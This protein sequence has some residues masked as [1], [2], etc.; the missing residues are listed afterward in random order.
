MKIYSIQNTSMPKPL[1]FKGSQIGGGGSSKPDSDFDVYG[2]DDE[3]SQERRNYIRE[4]Y[5]DY[6]I[7]YYTD[8]LSKEH[9][10]SDEKLKEMVNELG[11]RPHKVDYQTVIE[12]PLW[13][14]EQ[15]GN[16]SYRGQS[17][18]D[19]PE[20][21]KDLKEAGIERVID[22]VGYSGL[23]EKVEK[24]GLEYVSFP[25]RDDFH[26]SE[27]FK[28]KSSFL[29]R[30]KR[31][32]ENVVGYKDE[33]LEEYVRGSSRCYDTNVKNFKE[34]FIKFIQ[35]M[36]QDYVYIGCEFGTYKTDAALVLNNCFNPKAFN[37]NIY[38]KSNSTL[39]VE[40][41]HNLYYNLTDDDKRRM[42]YTKEFDESILPRL[43]EE[44]IRQKELEKESLRRWEE[45]YR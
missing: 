9:R 28:S 27:I 36:Q 13:N 1:Y 37:S 35:A 15:I 16:N 38:L 8:I 17:L 21:I 30:E 29:S 20:C 2:Y 3:I 45:S 10:V 39:D 31:F 25:L 43:R 40:G 14:L 34:K 11:K 41:L 6:K 32:A 4:H 42:N 5:E 24:E 23:Q 26:N 19:K 7:P 33:D 44:E 12:L 22:L 18:Y